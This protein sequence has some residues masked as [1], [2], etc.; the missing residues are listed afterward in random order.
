MESADGTLSRATVWKIQAIFP[1]RKVDFS[2][3]IKKEQ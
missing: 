3:G 2:Y 1:S